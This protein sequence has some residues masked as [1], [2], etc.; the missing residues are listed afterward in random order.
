MPEVILNCPQCQRQLRVTEDLV[1]RPVKCPACGLIF[2]VPMG[3]TEPQLAP[4]IC[5]MVAG[6]L[7]ILANLVHM[8]LILVVPQQKPGPEMPEF[9]R[10]AM[11]MMTPELVIIESIVFALISL[12]ILLA[13]I[14]MLRRRMFWLA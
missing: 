14:Q 13:G 11:E 7:G 1:G 10:K 5:L 8:L 3:G 2:T 6:M 9:F 4:A 12:V